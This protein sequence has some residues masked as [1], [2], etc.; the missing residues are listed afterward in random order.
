[1]N[2]PKS[3][4][5]DLMKLFI[6]T[7]PKIE[8]SQIRTRA[9]ILIIL[10]L[11]RTLVTLSLC[12]FFLFAEVKD[13]AF[14]LSLLTTVLALNFVAYLTS[15]TR[16]YKM[17]AAFIIIE[18]LIAVPVGVLNNPSVTSLLSA[19]VWLSLGPLIS[20]LVL[21]NRLT[22][23]SITATL[24]PFIVMF[25]WLPQQQLRN[26]LYVQFVFT[27][28]SSVL[29][30]LGTTL[31][32]RANQDLELERAK[33]HN[34][35][36]LASLGEVAGGIA[37][38]LNTPL[39]L[40]LLKSSFL[41]T[42]IRAGNEKVLNEV[43]AIKK[44][45]HRMAKVIRGLLS[46]ARD[47]QHDPREAIPVRKW[48]ENALKLCE[49]KFKN[50]GV[51]MEIDE[52][53]LDTVISVQS[54]QLSQV[55]VNLMNN[56]FDAIQFQE[57]QWIR[58][59]CQRRERSFDLVVQDSGSGVPKAHHDRLFQPFFTTKDV[60]K[61]M[62]LGLSLSKVI[63]HQHGGDLIYDHSCQNTCFIIRLPVADAQ[64]SAA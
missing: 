47:G 19:T 48:V 46:Y 9:K 49:K 60:G 39:G 40:L 22:I 31:R 63:L 62:G 37:H 14:V 34:I 17:G 25:S 58:I 23:L 52:E 4:Q 53:L 44:I 21:S 45:T 57:S 64:Q 15:R 24:V 16:F 35:S 50:S 36:K 1:M 32:D 28:A 61:G 51:D 54:V 8:S 20:S 6:S 13:R 38:E 5:M 10:V 59:S 26:V 55:L 2:R 3:S 18:P 27:M 11:C 56:S 12:V 41:E 7:S 43:I 33:S 42:E 29:A 30:L